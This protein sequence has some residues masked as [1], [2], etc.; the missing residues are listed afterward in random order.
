MYSAQVNAYLGRLT[1]SAFAGNGWSFLEGET[2]SKGCTTTSL[3]A[4]YRF[5]RIF[6]LALHW[7]NPFRKDVVVND[8][9]LLNRNL[10]RNL[11]VF[12]GDMG[13]KLTLQLNVSLSRGRKFAEAERILRPRKTDAGVMKHE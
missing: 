11:R 7:Q 12:S 10:H 6:N 8:I 1:L 3:S 9:E 5:N 2:K 13:N 4:S